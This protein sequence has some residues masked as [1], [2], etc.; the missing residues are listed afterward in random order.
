MKTP[1]WDKDYDKHSIHGAE[2][3]AQLM[4]A[5]T[6][7]LKKRRTAV[8]IGAHIGLTALPLAEM[9]DEVYAFEPEPE[10]YC[11]LLANTMDCGNVFR[12]CH[13]LGDKPGH[14]GIALPDDNNS[15]CWYLT[16]NGR[17]VTVATLDVFHFNN[18]DFIKIDVEGFEGRVLR[19][20]QHT[21]ARS[22]PT[23]FFEDNGVGPKYYRKSWVDPKVVLRELD[24]YPAAR[25]QKNEIWKPLT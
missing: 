17:G 7:G 10:N 25:M 4:R 5:A 8:D 3:Q 20:A 23:I 16:D 24:Y 21:I 13:A 15:G 22:R 14:S 12:L 6:Y 11:C 2:A 19:G 18:V 9:F 1:S